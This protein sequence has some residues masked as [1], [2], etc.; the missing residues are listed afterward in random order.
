MA[1]D[2]EQLLAQ[3]GQGKALPAYLLT[4]EAEQSLRDAARTIAYAIVPE[5]DRSFNLV[6]YDGAAAR[7]S[8]VADDLCSVSMLG[9][10]RVVL[11]LGATFLSGK[12]DQAELVDQ[13]AELWEQGREDESTRKAVVLFSEAGSR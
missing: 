9:G 3:I 5:V 4:G 11:V 10:R 12:R 13:L 7:P 1:A 2:L 6:K 8:E